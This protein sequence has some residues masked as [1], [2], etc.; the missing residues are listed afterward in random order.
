MEKYLS[1]IAWQPFRAWGLIC[2]GQLHLWMEQA[3]VLRGTIRLT[4][5]AHMAG[6]HDP[7]EH[8][9]DVIDV[10]VIFCQSK[11]W[12]RQVFRHNRWVESVSG[13]T[14]DI[15]W[16][17]RT[18]IL[19]QEIN[20]SITTYDS[21]SIYRKPDSAKEVDT[22]WYQLFP[23]QQRWNSSIYQIQDTDGFNIHDNRDLWMQ[24]IQFP[25][26]IHFPG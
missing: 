26:Y 9:Y 18:E 1:H 7:R 3:N 20:L 21:I 19:R 6:L 2:I 16:F 22:A 10:Y 15:D 17:R 24:S 14:R 12:Y 25:D 5:T 23:C 4:S 11:S 8:N 13:N